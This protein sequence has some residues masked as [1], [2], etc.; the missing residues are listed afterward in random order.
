MQRTT[1]ITI[2]VLLGLTLASAAAQTTGAPQYQVDVMWPKPLPN[3]WILGSVTGVAVDAQDHVWILH[4]ASSNQAGTELGTG[5][6][7]PTAEVCCSAAPPVLEFDAD[8]NLLNH[9]GG[10]GQGYDWP[11]APGG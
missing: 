7:P 6:N 5:T 9:W 11:K 8:G 1:G 10:P 2:T 3:H 4:T